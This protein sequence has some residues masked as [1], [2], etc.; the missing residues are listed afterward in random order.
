MHSLVEQL[1]QRLAP[2]GTLAFTFI[3]PHYRSSPGGYHG[4]NLRWRLEKALGR[5]GAGEVDRVM[6]RSRDADWCSLVDG[7]QLHVNSNGAWVNEAQ[8]CMTYNVFYSVRFLRREFPY[9]TIRPPVNGEM[10]HCCLIQR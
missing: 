6:E 2:G 5:K 9:A 10:Q 4:N 1:E 7:T 8:R 3:D